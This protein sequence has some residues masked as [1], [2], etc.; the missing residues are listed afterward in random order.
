MRAFQG[1]VG[2]AT[3]AL[4]R[5][6]A[7]SVANFRYTNGLVETEGLTRLLIVWIESAGRAQSTRDEESRYA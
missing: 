5:A 6:A 4:G 2:G 3:L 1:E 7:G